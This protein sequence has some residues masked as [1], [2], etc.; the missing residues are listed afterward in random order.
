MVWVF[1]FE[2]AYEFSKNFASHVIFFKYQEDFIWHN[3][4]KYL[5]YNCDGIKLSSIWTYISSFIHWASDSPF[6]YRSYKIIYWDAVDK[7]KKKKK[8]K[9]GKLC[10]WCSCYWIKGDCI[11]PSAIYET[12]RCFLVALYS[13]TLT[14]LNLEVV[15]KRLFH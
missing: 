1:S 7:I 3:K 4:Q 10:W 6:L 8:K 13:L 15:T 9:I 5:N 12:N 2:T 11:Y 14:K